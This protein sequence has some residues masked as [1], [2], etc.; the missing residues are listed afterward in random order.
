[1]DV[2]DGGWGCGFHRGGDFD[3]AGMP[4]AGSGNLTTMCGVSCWPLFGRLYDR[5]RRARR[6]LPMDNVALAET[7]CQ[8]R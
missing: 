6:L 3:N 2:D 4:P 8:S 5:R 7:R 1:M